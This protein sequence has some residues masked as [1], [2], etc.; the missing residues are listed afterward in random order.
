MSD[1]RVVFVHAHPD[2]EA[3]TT[4]GTIA[5]YADEGAH[6]CLVTCTNGEAGE[7]AEVPEFGTV[8]EIRPRL[9]EIRRAELEEACRRLGAIDLRMLGY[10][11]SGMDGTPSNDA[12]HAFV[13][14]NFGEVVQKVADVLADVRPHVLVTYNAFGGYGHPD[15]IRAHQAALA[16]T[17]EVP[18]SKVYFTAI[19][20]SVMRFAQEVTKELGFDEFFSDA[21]IE[22]IGIDDERVTSVIDVTR[23]VP[24]KIA[25]L[26]AH[27]TQLG[28]TAAFLEMPVG[29]RDAAL[30]TEYYE[31]LRSD[32]PRA[33]TEDDLFAGL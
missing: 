23:Y 30:A 33:A 28:T 9:G 31:R 1:R 29:F 15:H 16:A 8:E 11:D 12:P 20:R 3:L 26:E 18:V 5:R 13:K 22:R 6:V 7:I 32:V 17:E 19:P 2:D 21:D 14:Q 25:A 10:H 24:H 4:G 27:R